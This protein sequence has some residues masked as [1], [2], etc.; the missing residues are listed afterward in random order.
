M[1]NEA[2]PDVALRLI[3]SKRRERVADLRERVRSCTIKVIEGNPDKRYTCYFCNSVIE[4][5]ALLLVDET[6]FMGKES[7]TE[8]SACK[9]CHDSAKHLVYCGVAHCGEVHF[10]LS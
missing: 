10:S 9:S 5:K 3:G 7:R 2:N 4:G 8:Y 6:P 1:A